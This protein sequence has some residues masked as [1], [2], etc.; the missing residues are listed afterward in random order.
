ML[1]AMPSDDELVA[2]F[3]ALGD[4][5]RLRIVRFLLDQGGVCCAIPG[6]V[7]AC[8]IVAA[9]GL[10]QPT[11]SHHM[12]ILTQAGLVTGRKAGKWMHYTL[13]PGRCAALAA[14]LTAIGSH[15][16]ASHAA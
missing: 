15:A 11:V 14:W 4:P 6:R 3:R 5:V 1:S 2:A 9:L 10:S 12:A 7:C 16:A 13:D 8:D